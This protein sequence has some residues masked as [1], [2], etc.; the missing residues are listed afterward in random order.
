MRLGDR[1][2]YDPEVYGTY[3]SQIPGY[4]NDDADFDGRE[5][6]HEGPDSRPWTSAVYIY[7][8]EHTRGAGDKDMEGKRVDKDIELQG[9][10]SRSGAA[11]DKKPVKG[12]GDDVDDREVEA[13]RPAPESRSRRALSA[14][15]NDN[16]HDSKHE[17][18]HDD[19]E[20]DQ[21]PHAAPCS[22]ANESKSKEGGIK[23][24]AKSDDAVQA[25]RPAPGF[26]HRHH[27]R[28]LAS[29]R[30]ASFT[31]LRRELAAYN[32]NH[33]QSTDA[34]GNIVG[35]DREEKAQKAPRTQPPL[36]YE[37]MFKAG[38]V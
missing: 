18:D 14:A 28:K 2:E 37:V 6:E 8:Y 27:Q 35:V 1:D 21:A 29:S 38:D 22:K 10:Q 17:Y 32:S 12:K 30:L 23:G 24:D 34:G 13:P 26:P 25:P 16:R 20:I 33:S 11:G 15:E 5:H 31:Q 3:G 36:E 19:D 7:D 9:G 4:G